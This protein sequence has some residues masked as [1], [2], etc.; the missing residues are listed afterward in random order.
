MTLPLHQIL[1]VRSNQGACRRHGRDEKCVKY[2]GWKSERRDHL[3]DLFVEG[4]II[5]ERIL[6]K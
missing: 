5:L 6:G 3:E 2:F 1:L 4:R